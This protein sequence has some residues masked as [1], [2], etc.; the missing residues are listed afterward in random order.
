M[1]EGGTKGERRANAYWCVFYSYVLTDSI[2]SLTSFASR[3]CPISSRRFPH[4]AVR[5]RVVQISYIFSFIMQMDVLWMQSFLGLAKCETQACSSNTASKF[6]LLGFWNI[7]WR[8]R[9]VESILCSK[10]SF[11]LSSE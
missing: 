4:A 11:P 3:A 1:R 10:W 5:G 9:I 8:R 2:P 6:E 7:M